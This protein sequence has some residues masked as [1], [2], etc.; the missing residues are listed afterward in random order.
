MLVD[1]IRVETGCAAP[2]GA[3]DHV[4]ERIDRMNCLPNGRTILTAP[5]HGSS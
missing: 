3:D 1:G 2:I 5:P 4:N